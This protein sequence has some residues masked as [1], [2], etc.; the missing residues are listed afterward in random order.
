MNRVDRNHTFTDLL[1]D[2]LNNVVVLGDDRDPQRF[3]AHAKLEFWGED[4]IGIHEPGVTGTPTLHEGVVTLDGPAGK[5]EWFHGRRYSRVH[6]QNYQSALHWV[7]TFRERPAQDGYTF[8]LEN[9]QPYHWFHQQPFPHPRREVR[10]GVPWLVQMEAD[11]TPCERPEAIDGSVAVYHKSKRDNWTARGGKNYRTGKV[12]HIPRPL[13]VDAVGK[14]AWLRLDVKTGRYTAT[15]PAAFW[16]AAVYPVRINDTFGYWC[17][18]ASSKA[19]SAD[20]MSGY[21]FACPAAGTAQSMVLSA[22]LANDW[23]GILVQQSDETI[24]ANGVTNAATCPASQGWVTATFGTPPTLAAIE[25]Y[26]CLLFDGTTYYYHDDG[27]ANAELYDSSNSFAS[28]EDPA[29]ATYT[30]NRLLSIYVNYTPSGGG[31]SIPVARRHY[32]NQRVA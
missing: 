17:S 21:P 12:L 32:R 27:E 29:D 6:P 31:L 5:T 22:S 30:T 16:E 9:W 18:G 1:G 10:D 24:I 25:Y 19:R 13:A 2:N 26:L 8:E 15:A 11:G 20:Q 23:K 28:P 4:W 3:H 14:T 7:K